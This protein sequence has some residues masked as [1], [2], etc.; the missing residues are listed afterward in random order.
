MTHEVFTPN[1]NTLYRTNYETRLLNIHK[2]GTDHY[3]CCL[4]GNKGTVESELRDVTGRQILKSAGILSASSSMYLSTDKDY[5]EFKD[6]DETYIYDFNGHLITSGFY[7]EKKY[8]GGGLSCFIRHFR[9]NG[10]TYEEIIWSRK[11]TKTFTDIY[12][13]RGHAN[14]GRYI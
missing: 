13:G 1:A 12:G 5:F 7:V 6:D 14:I 2:R 8:I 3:Y 9:K 11:R 10:K 4:V